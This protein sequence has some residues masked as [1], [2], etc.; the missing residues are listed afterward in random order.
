MWP[1]GGTI[2]PFALILILVGGCLPEVPTVKGR[3]RPGRAIP[4]HTYVGMYG[5]AGWASGGPFT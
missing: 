2:T 1:G 4:T 3:L 5:V